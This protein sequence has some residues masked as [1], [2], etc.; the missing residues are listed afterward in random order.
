MR[1][2]F[3][4]HGS[5]NLPSLFDPLPGIDISKRYD[6]YCSRHNEVIVYRNVLFKGV[7]SI[8]PGARHDIGNS[9]VELEQ[10]NGEIIFI[11][12]MQIVTF[13]EHGT[14]LSFETL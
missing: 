5:P 7:K 13:C 4:S 11:T 12:R 2:S 3:G 10:A 9:F 14:N 1:L 8:L 6:L